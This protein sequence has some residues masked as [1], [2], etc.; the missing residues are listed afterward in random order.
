MFGETR[1]VPSFDE[2]GSGMLFRVNGGG[3][4]GMGEKSAFTG[5]AVWA[6]VT[7]QLLL[8]KSVGRFRVRVSKGARV[9]GDAGFVWV[10][11][12]EVRTRGR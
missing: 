6:G 4:R 10:P 8:V 7:F 9:D 3:G 2:D 12:P 11:F 1:E 5:D